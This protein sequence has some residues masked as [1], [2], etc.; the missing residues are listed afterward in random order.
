MSCSTCERSSWAACRSRCRDCRTG[1]D[2]ARAL[3]VAQPR[4][5]VAASFGGEVEHIPERVKGIV[6]AV[7]LAG[8]GRHVE[9][10]RTPEMT[11]WSAVAAGHVEPRPGPFHA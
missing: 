2:Y 6:V 9:D 8:L 10:F 4:M 11:D 3:G 5:K 1:T 7:F